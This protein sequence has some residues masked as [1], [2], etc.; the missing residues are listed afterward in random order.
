MPHDPAAHSP[1]EPASP[2]LVEVTRG[3]IAESLHRG[4]AAIADASGKLLGT[5]GDVGRPVYPRSAIKSLQAIPLVESGAADAFG[6]GDEELALACA[7]HGGELAHTERVSAWLERIGC[8]AADLEC[9]SHAPT[10]APAA[11][12]LVRAGTEPTPLHNNC[13]GKH[14]GFLTTARHLG[15]PTEGYRLFEHPV[16]QRVLGALE[17][18]TGQELGAAPRGLDGCSIPT[19]AIPVEALAFAMA[20]LADPRDLPDR[21]IDAVLRLRRA[22]GGQPFYVA[23][24]GRFDTVLMEATGGRVL[25]KTGA[26]GVYCAC[27]PELGLGIALKIDDGALRAAQV[28]VAALLREVGALDDAAW[29]ALEPRINPPI[30]TRRGFD[31]GAVRPAASFPADDPR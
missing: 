15:E 28:A 12:A 25:V 7:S 20:R 6:L 8:S 21:R 14:T 2:L 30:E 23:G 10:C 3:P 26:E 18:M 22:W 1:A 29:K 31:A 16:Q 9:G 19:I 27:L 4:V 5:W 17:Q 13:S 24:S 11:A